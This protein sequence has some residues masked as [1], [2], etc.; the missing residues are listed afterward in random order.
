VRGHR[1]GTRNA[2]E[3]FERPPH[4]GTAYAGAGSHRTPP[5]VLESMRSLAAA[6]AA[7]GLVLRTGAS[8]GADRAF[9]DG[10]LASGGRVELYLPYADF[11]D[12]HWRERDPALLRVLPEPSPAA[13]ELA[14]RVHPRWARLSCAE[15]R[16][17]ARDCHQVIGPDLASPAALLVC[18]TAAGSLDGR[19]EGREGTAQAL[20]VAH[21]REVPV[22]NLARAGETRRVRRSAMCAAAPRES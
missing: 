9:A 10:A 8:P 11:E 19:G 20:R 15:R 3:H 22:F 16:L 17:R 2:V 1:P 4:P 14:A 6:F 13:F 18:W 5:A 7:N 12:E 21:A